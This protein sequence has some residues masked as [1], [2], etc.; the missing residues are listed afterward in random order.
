MLPGLRGGSILD[1]G[2]GS[3]EVTIPLLERANRLLFV[4]SSQGMINLAM[5][6]VPVEH[7]DNVRGVCASV[8]DFSTDERFDA[9]VCIGVLA[10]VPTWRKALGKLCSWVMADGRLIVQ[11]TDHAATMGR[12]T[13]QLGRFS[14][15]ILNRATHHHER[16]TFVEVERTLAAAGFALKE[17]RRYCFVPGLRAL[18]GRL[19]AAVVHSASVGPFASHHGGEVIATFQRTVAISNN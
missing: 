17:S 16:M 3:G 4:D 11:L 5:Q 9:V 13:H 12:M 2:A 6:N 15:M 7:R 19:S 10:H 18:P 14:S 8:T 1:V